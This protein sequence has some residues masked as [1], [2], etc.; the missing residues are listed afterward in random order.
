MPSAIAHEIVVLR[1]RVGEVLSFVRDRS[2][3]VG[4]IVLDVDGN[5]AERFLR[6]RSEEMETI[7]LDFE[8]RCVIAIAKHQPVASDLADIICLYRIARDIDRIMY[9]ILSIA[10]KV[11]KLSKYRFL[12]ESGHLFNR[13]ALIRQVGHVESMLACCQLLVKEYRPRL[14]ERV[15]QAHLEVTDIKRKVKKMSGA[16]NVSDV[17]DIDLVFNVFALSRHYDRISE[18]IFSLVNDELAKMKSV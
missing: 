14:V 15:K 8:K 12:K 18:T 13:A 10:K 1:H 3:E 7:V 16:M 9:L 6:E 11:L 2:I 4:I 5:K 17:Q